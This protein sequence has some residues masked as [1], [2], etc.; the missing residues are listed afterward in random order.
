MMKA[1]S[2]IRVLIVDDERLLRWSLATKL[3]KWGYEVVEAGTAREAVSNTRAHQPDII[4]LDLKL[5]DASGLDILPELY[6]ANPDTLVIILTAY[7]SIEDAVRAIKSGAVDFFTKPVDFTKL[8]F[9][10]RMLSEN[11]QLKRKIQTLESRQK[12]DSHV[13]IVAESPLMKKVLHDARRIAEADPSA[14]LITGESG[15]GKNILARYIHEYSPRKHRPFIIVDCASIPETLMESELFGYERGA[16]TDARTSKKGTFLLAKGGILVLDEI[17]EMRQPLQAK[18]L[19]FLEERSF[20]PLGSTQEIQ[21]DVTIIATTN[22]DLAK[23]VSDG[24]FREDLYYRLNVVHIQIPPLRERKED[25]LPLADYYMALYN[26]RFH[27]EIRGLTKRAQ[28]ALLEYDWPGNVRELRNV[29]ERAM[30]LCTKHWLDVQHLGFQGREGEEER[31][32]HIPP[33]GI[34]LEKL[35][36]DLILQALQLSGGNKS[37]AARLLGLTRDTFR[38]RLKKILERQSERLGDFTRDPG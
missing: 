27:R 3:K 28:Q 7:G 29:I 23:M 14:I 31:V 24:D 11:I 13:F 18:L 25:I 26:E 34:N 17:G 9:T 35:E 22:R 19:R 10:L 37:K 30:I 4:M 20:R 21:V 32:F 38:Y 2:S 1:Q 8:E 15:V 6:D 12:D 36:E 33:G 16:F 5:P